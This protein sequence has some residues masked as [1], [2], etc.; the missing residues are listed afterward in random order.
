MHLVYCLHEEGKQ[1]ST[2][3]LYKVFL[4]AGLIVLA[5]ILGGFLGVY[6]L[7]KAISTIGGWF[8]LVA[9][10]AF[11]AAIVA[12]YVYDI[13]KEKKSGTVSQPEIP[14]QIDDSETET[15]EQDGRKD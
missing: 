9:G 15:D 1:M 10:A 14:E 5:G 4:I 8:Y 6:V 13:R 11:V 7:F 12:L 3:P 2:R